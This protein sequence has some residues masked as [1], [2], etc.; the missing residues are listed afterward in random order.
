MPIEFK[1]EGT[2]CVRCNKSD[3]DVGKITHYIDPY[4]GYEG[5]LCSG[6]IEQREKPYKEIC[7]KCKRVAY[8]HGGMSAYGFV[9]EFEKMCLECVEEKEVKESKKI[10][11]NLTIKNFVKNNW[12][13]LIGISITIIFGIIG[14]SI[15]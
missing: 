8:N 5:L 4:D 2:V 7:P 1:Q 13:F 15:L 11:R 14:L 9:D 12:K 10:T 3:I 6:C